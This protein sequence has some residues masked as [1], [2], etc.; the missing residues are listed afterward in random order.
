MRTSLPSRTAGPKSGRVKATVLPLNRLLGIVA[1]SAGADHL[2][3][4]AFTP[5]LICS[6]KATR[7]KTLALSSFRNWPRA[8]VS[9]A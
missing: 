8:G 1:A 7:T 4:M 6:P 2:S 9:A 3:E 5:P